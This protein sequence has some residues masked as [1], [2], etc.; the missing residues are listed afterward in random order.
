MPKQTPNRIRK[1]SKTQAVILASHLAT[2]KLKEEYPE[3][4]PSFVPILAVIKQLQGTVGYFSKKD[5]IQY[6]KDHGFGYRQYERISTIVNGIEAE[7]FINPLPQQWFTS[8]KYEATRKLDYFMRR[9]AVHFN[10]FIED[11]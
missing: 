3:L 2:A 7:Q 10:R 11:L 4:M 8:R 1:L 5:I 9:Y 6:L